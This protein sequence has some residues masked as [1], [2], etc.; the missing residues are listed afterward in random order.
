ADSTATRRRM[1]FD[2]ALI[3]TLAVG[4]LY[5][6]ARVGLAPRDPS[7]G[8]AVVFAPWTKSDAAFARAVEPGARFVRFGAFP[9]IVVVVPDRPGYAARVLAD[10]AL[11]IADPQ[12]L[13]SC[14]TGPAGAGAS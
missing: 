8:V 12:A 14:L 3:A 10:G 5:A 13:V 1:A 4:G 6:V 11:L 7:A 9:F 2:L